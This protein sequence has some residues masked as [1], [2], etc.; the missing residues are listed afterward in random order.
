MYIY[1][2]NG[3]LFSFVLNKTQL[4]IYVDLFKGCKVFCTSQKI[5]LLLK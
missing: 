1:N 3:T 2:L 5:V 4:T